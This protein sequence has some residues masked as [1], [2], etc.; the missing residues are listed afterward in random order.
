M[1]AQ[2]T[3]LSNEI[4]TE[5]EAIQARQ[6]EAIKAPE[7]LFPQKKTSVTAEEVLQGRAAWPAS[8]PK[9]FE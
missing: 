3:F 6:V 2:D 9:F 4:R 8:E 1:I 5:E 7:S